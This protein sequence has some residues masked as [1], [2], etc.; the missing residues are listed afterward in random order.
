MLLNLLATA[1]CNIHLRTLWPSASSPPFPVP[2]ALLTSYLSMMLSYAFHTYDSLLRCTTLSS[3]EL[4]FSCR[5]LQ[6]TPSNFW[7][8]LCDSTLIIKI[9]FADFPLLLLTT[10]R[11]FVLFYIIILKINWVICRLLRAI[12]IR[13]IYAKIDDLSHHRKSFKFTWI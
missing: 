2:P 4:Q 5:I 6:V 12:L 8:P 1:K 10:A 13:L 7:T 9:T 3:D 11:I